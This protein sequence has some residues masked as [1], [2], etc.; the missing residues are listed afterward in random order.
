M[1]KK[2]RRIIF[3][4]FSVFFVVIVMFIR[5]SGRQ[6]H[7]LLMFDWDK[8]R[9][10]RNLNFE[11]QMKHNGRTFNRYV[12]VSERVR[13]GRIFG[14]AAPR[15]DRRNLVIVLVHNESEAADFPDN[16]I[17][18]WP[19]IDLVDY[20][21]TLGESVAG[22]FNWAVNKCE[23]ELGTIRWSRQ[24]LSLE[25]F[26]LTYPLQITDLVDNWEK[27]FAL[28]NM[29]LE[30]ERDRIRVR[31]H[32]WTP[33]PRNKR[34]FASPLGFGFNFLIVV[35]GEMRV[36]PYVTD[37]YM[38]NPWHPDFDRF[39]D[40]LAFVRNEDDAQG[41]LDSVVVAWPIDYCV[42]L[43]RRLKILNWEVMRDHF[44]L[45]FGGNRPATRSVVGIEGLKIN[46][47]LTYPITADDLVDNWQAVLRLMQDIRLNW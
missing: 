36:G 47:G 42:E 3:A 24:V 15:S 29:L 30:S 26:G 20:G 13:N 45:T 28:Y 19:S 10:A 33:I 44:S 18:A 40:T 23:E 5:N 7:E 41:F 21:L 16:V 4:F 43:Q 6:E 1:S 8:Y 12:D 38:V 11:W 34:I 37:R 17:A 32:L 22:R 46:Y 27:V 2:T 25:E 14:V 31:G 35:D 39:F 9:Y